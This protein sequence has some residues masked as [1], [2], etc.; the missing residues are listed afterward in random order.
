MLQHFRIPFWRHGTCGWKIT[1]L[2]S[3]RVLTVNVYLVCRD[4]FMMLLFCARMSLAS[5]HVLW[6]HNWNNYNCSSTE[7]ISNARK[8][9]GS[10]RREMTARRGRSKSTTWTCARDEC[11]RSDNKIIHDNISSGVAQWVVHQI[12]WVHVEGHCCDILFSFL[13][14]LQVCITSL[15]NGWEVKLLVSA[16]L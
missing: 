11:H 13:N 10:A 8:E 7:N 16:T 5:F 3:L 6:A 12:I 15:H 4:Y 14:A 1:I 2:C 9:S